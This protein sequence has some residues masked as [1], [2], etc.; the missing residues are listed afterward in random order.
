MS[1]LNALRGSQREPG[2]RECPQGA[3]CDKS[4]I[5]SGRLRVILPCRHMV[6]P[7]EMDVDEVQ[8]DLMETEPPVVEVFSTTKRIGCFPVNCRLLN[9]TCLHLWM[10]LGNQSWRVLSKQSS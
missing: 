7:P 2:R 8:F 3:F 4:K 9:H 10:N 1:R 5:F 6:L